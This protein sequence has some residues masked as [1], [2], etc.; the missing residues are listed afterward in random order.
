MTEAIV[1]PVREA[2][3]NA[4]VRATFEDIKRA[5]ALDE[6]PVIFRLI[7]RLPI[8]LDTSWR[9]L[10]FAFFDEGRLGVRTKWMLGLAVS[11]SNN[12]K[13]M[14]LECTRMLRMHGVSDAELAE[15]MAV[16]DVT[17]GLNKTLK[18]AGALAGD[19]D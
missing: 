15:L 4:Q 14:I 5:Y 16:V 8:Y 3:A 19:K 13:P 2:E 12:N 7:A 10:R 18:A 17:N 6:V 1:A 9:R 11:A